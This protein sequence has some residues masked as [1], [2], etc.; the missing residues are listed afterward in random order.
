[1]GSILQFV[2]SYALSLGKS[3]SPTT[4]WV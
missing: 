2:F 1:M 4:N 3:D